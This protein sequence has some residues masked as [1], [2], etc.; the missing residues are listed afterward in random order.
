MT[1]DSIQFEALRILEI[2]SSTPFD[3]CFPLTKE[4]NALPTRPGLYAVRHR[5]EGILYIGKALNVRNRFMGGHKALYCAY[6]D[7]LNPDDERIAVVTVMFQQRTQLLELE[8]LMLQVAKPRYNSRIRQS[9][10]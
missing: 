8:A 2:L 9:E 6:L 7:R 1:D 3:E 5:D 10:D 4:L